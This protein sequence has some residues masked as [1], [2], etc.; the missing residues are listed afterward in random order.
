MS[1]GTI[2]E[3]K[4]GKEDED[5][6]RKVALDS[7]PLQIIEPFT[8]LSLLFMHSKRDER[9]HLSGKHASLFGMCH[10]CLCLHCQRAACRCPT[11]SFPACMLF[12]SSYLS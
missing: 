5:L 3:D 9:K 4:N 12:F 10:A 7:V 8:F 11:I 2:D 6:E 1:K